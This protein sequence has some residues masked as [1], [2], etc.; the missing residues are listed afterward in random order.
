[1]KK[2][3]WHSLIIQKENIVKEGKKDILIRIPKG[4]LYQ[5]KVFWHLK[6]LVRE[7]KQGN[8]ISIAFTD[9]FKFHLRSYKDE[10]YDACDSDEIVISA[11]ELI[12]LIKG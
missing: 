12:Q 3:K 1:M 5:G 11:E 4:S 2:T 10:N 9:E 8:T 7:G 6:K